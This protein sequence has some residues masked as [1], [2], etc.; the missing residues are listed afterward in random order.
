MCDLGM[1][2]LHVTGTIVGRQGLRSC[3]GVMSCCDVCL[4]VCPCT[5]IASS[6]MHVLHGFETSMA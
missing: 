6:S 4:V 5:R 3:A 1:V 2:K